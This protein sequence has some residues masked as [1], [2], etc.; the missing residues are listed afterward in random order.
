MSEL[1]AIVPVGQA[2]GSFCPQHDT[3]QGPRGLLVGEAAH[4][5][6]TEGSH[7]SLGRSYQ[8][9]VTVNASFVVPPIA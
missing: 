1:T 2:L 8:A 7:P 6:S 4:R 5:S 3:P 9:K